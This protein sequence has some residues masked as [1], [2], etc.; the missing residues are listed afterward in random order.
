MCVC[1]CVCSYVAWQT[2][3]VEVVYRSQSSVLP[4]L[5]RCGALCGLL[6]VAVCLFMPFLLPAPGF[7][8]VTRGL[9]GEDGDI[10]QFSKLFDTKPPHSSAAA[11]ALNRGTV[12]LPTAS[13][14]RDQFVTCQSSSDNSDSDGG[15]TDSDSDSSTHGMDDSGIV[16]PPIVAFATA[17][18]APGSAGAATT[19]LE[20][21]SQEE[22]SPRPRKRARVHSPSLPRAT[23]PASAATA[24][25]VARAEAVAHAE[26]E[27]GEGKSEA[28]DLDGCE[29]GRLG[30]QPLHAEGWEA[31][32]QWGSDSD[33]SEDGSSDSGVDSASPGGC[34]PP[35]RAATRRDP[36]DMDGGPRHLTRHGVTN[37]EYGAGTQPSG[38][39]QGTGTGTGST[40]GASRGGHQHKCD[41]PWGIVRGGDQ[42]WTD[43]HSQ[44][45]RSRRSRG[46]GTN[47]ALAKSEEWWS[48]LTLVAQHKG[49]FILR[50]RLNPALSSGAWLADIVWGTRRHRR[51]RRRQKRDRR[52][53]VCLRLC[54]RARSGVCVCARVFV[55]SWLVWLV[56]ACGCAWGVPSGNCLRGG[57]DGSFLGLCM[58]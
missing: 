11:P 45:S 15:S 43:N 49:K 20:V 50:S 30:V 28:L 39:P 14:A 38:Q 12:R 22:S 5:A 25:A 2:Q 7:L 6:C 35:S 10:L 58:T 47:S 3:N 51:Q 13:D 54:E 26:G 19:P 52:A 27:G 33:G 29:P 41:A 48:P 40:N 42:R 34:R 56:A 21:A 23:R 55:S 17:P 16:S 44:R 32:I 9:K 53:L 37:S 1:V 46:G 8:C 31:A 36:P 18:A 4:V 24:A 57:G